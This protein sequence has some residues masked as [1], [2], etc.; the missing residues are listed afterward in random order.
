[1]ACRCSHAKGQLC[2]GYHSFWWSSWLDGS[3]CHAAGAASPRIGA[4]A[5]LQLPVAVALLV[6]APYKSIQDLVG[7]HKK[8]GVAAHRF[9]RHRSGHKWCEA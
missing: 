7:P 6:L 4:W 8:W 2:M 9:C 5:S 1:M 3:H